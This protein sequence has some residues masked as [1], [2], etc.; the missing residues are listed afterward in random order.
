MELQHTVSSL[1]WAFFG[2]VVTLTFITAL[3]VYFD[4]TDDNQEI[5]EE[6]YRIRNRRIYVDKDGMHFK[7]IEI[8]EHEEAISGDDEPLF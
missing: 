2:F 6:Y 3:I 1:G 8:D 5:Q 4:K 7:T